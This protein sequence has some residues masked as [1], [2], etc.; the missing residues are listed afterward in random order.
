GGFIDAPGLSYLG[1]LFGTPLAPRPGA[2]PCADCRWAH[3]R[4]RLDHCRRGQP[5]ND[6]LRDCGSMHAP[7]LEIPH[8]SDS[9]HSGRRRAWMDAVDLRNFEP[10]IFLVSRPTCQSCSPVRFELFRRQKPAGGRATCPSHSPRPDCT[11]DADRILRH[12]AVGKGAMSLLRSTRLLR[13]EACDPVR[14]M[15][16]QA[17]PLLARSPK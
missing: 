7:L 4:Q 11:C 17:A 2:W 1:D 13:G 12:C 15:S 14:A 10:S 9:H 8:Q 3:L 6:R 5:L 16:S